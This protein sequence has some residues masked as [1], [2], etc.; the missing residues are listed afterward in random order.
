MNRKQKIALE[1]KKNRD[2]KKEQFKNMEEEVD[3]LRD[4]ITELERQLIE[5]KS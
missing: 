3:N 1:N 2:R 4:R 5:G